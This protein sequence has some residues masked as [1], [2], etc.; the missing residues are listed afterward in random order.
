MK[1]Q[2]EPFWAKERFRVSN[3]RSLSVCLS[4]SLSCTHTNAIFTP[5]WL[6]DYLM[7]KAFMS[8]TKEETETVCVEGESGEGLQIETS[9]L[10]SP[11]GPT[12]LLQDSGM[13]AGYPHHYRW[14][15]GISHC[16]AWTDYV[17]VWV[18]SLDFEW[19]ASSTQR[20]KNIIYPVWGKIHLRSLEGKV[21][22]K[23]KL[24]QDCFVPVLG[25]RGWQPVGF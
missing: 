18:L 5:G 2:G 10:S 21:K 9:S 12:L 25:V 4:V 1:C 24:V 22:L 14:F 8:E 6:L 20:S 7:V 13:W 19:E 3:D 23:K 17:T 11:P 15:D 16:Q